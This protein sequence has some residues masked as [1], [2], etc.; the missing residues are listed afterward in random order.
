MVDVN[1][2]GGIRGGTRE[3]KV[4]RG[5]EFGLGVGMLLGAKERGKSGRVEGGERGECCGGGGSS[6]GRGIIV[7]AAKWSGDG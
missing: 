2:G 6:R 3:W 4:D 7:V 1:G 5:E